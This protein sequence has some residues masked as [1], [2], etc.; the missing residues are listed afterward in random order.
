MHEIM[1]N[2]RDEQLRQQCE[3]LAIKHW[4][5]A[6]VLVDA[7]D[8]GMRAAVYLPED[9]VEPAASAECS[10]THGTARAA[11]VEVLALIRQQR[12]P[13]LHA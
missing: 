13:L 11:L 3:L 6:R 7:T 12:A 1:L 10:A 9:G 8:G 4:P 5:G 2:S